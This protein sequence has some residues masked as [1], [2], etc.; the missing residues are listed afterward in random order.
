V[1]LLSLFAAAA[2]TL[3]QAFVSDYRLFVAERFLAGAFIGGMLP[4]L[5]AMIGKAAGE[6][7]RA[8]VYGVTASAGFMGGFL[9]PLSG[10]FI[11]AGL[12]LPA[13][14]VV[15]SVVM[16]AAFAWVLAKAPPDERL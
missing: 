15:A 7:E 1:L 2:A 8:A 9:G 11:A 6:A 14:F 3:P 5:N 12:G 4:T 13:V 16:L 10:G